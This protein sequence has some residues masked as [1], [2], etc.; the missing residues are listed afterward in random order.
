[1]A[2][3]INGTDCLFRVDALG[4]MQDLICAET[5]SIEV[6]PEFVEITTQGSGKAKSFDYDSYSYTISFQGAAKVEDEPDRP[7]GFDM[8]EKLLAFEELDYELHF[9]DEDGST[10]KITGTILVSKLELTQPL[11]DAARSN[12]DFQ[13]TGEL[14]MTT[15]STGGGSDNALIDADGTALID[16]SGEELIDA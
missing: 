12:V 3:F 11:N 7:T 14:T 6:T 1:M 5:V 13:G 9:V 15:T 8:L 10:K 4:G 16:S 2:G